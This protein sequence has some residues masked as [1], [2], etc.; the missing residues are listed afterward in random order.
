M[1]ANGGGLAHC[2]LLYRD[3]DE[4]LAGT[5]PFVHE[6]FGRDDE[7]L[8]AL[9]SHNL[10]LLRGA[11]GPDADRVAFVAMEQFGRNPARLI[12][13]WRDF[14]DGRPPDAGGVR[15]I[16]EPIW[17]GRSAA[18][19]DE[20]TR[21]EALLNIA[22][23]EAGALELMCPYDAVALDDRVLAGAEHNHPVLGYGVDAVASGRYLDPL[24]RNGPF[25]GTLDPP[26]GPVTELAFAIAQLADLRRL[27]AREARAA[28][29]PSER[30]DELVIAATEI[31]TNGVRHGGGSGI[32]RLWCDARILACEI[33]SG[34]RLSDPLA[35]RVRPSQ[36]AVDGRGLW[37]ANQLCDLVQIR[38][39]DAGTVV[40]LLMDR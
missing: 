32:A 7:I 31:A 29:L 9:P 37:I 13:A 1:G 28:G 3:E 21:H 39:G 11:L 24:T 17:A 36:T 25:A 6:G 14:L 19:I 30:I 33:S 18:E 34:G 20:G 23:E 38:S 35:G 27:V 26:T 8:I 10:E 5:V 40:R 22:F 12:P 15:G 2:A 4:F 16:G